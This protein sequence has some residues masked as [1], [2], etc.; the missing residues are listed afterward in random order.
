[1][2]TRSRFL[3]VATGAAALMAVAAPLSV[4]AAYP[5]KPITM[6]VA[7][8]AGG[9][10]DVT[11]RMLAPYIEKH[12][13]G[14]RIEVV[15][16]PGAGGEIGFAAL[17]DSPADGYTI[18]FINTPNLVSIPIE[19]QARFSLDR[20]DP[21]INVVDD[22]GIWTVPADSPFKTLSEAVAHAKANPNAV[23]VGTTGVGSDDQL[24]MLLVQRQ[25]G[26]QFTHVPFSGS[27]ANQKAMLAKKIQVCAQNLG[28]GLRA[29]ATEQVRILG[30]MSSERWKVAPDLPTFK[31]Q[32]YAVNM[33]SL[34]GI[35]APK[36]LPADIR[37]KLVDAL[38]KAV[39]DPEFVAKAEAKETFQPLR[40]LASDAFAGEL[41]QLDKELRAL[42]QSSPWLK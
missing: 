37:A 22:P 27:A 9:S 40:V 10:T 24:A 28:E 15:N 39:G 17:A 16:R 13:G 11:A 3:A 30:V 26:V 41:A 2:N 1:M 8:D 12:L 7:Y 38:T 23:T 18:G 5:E 14:A 20:L 35:G 21:L 31:E 29:T 34:R 33:A 6:V 19:R 4:Q 25:A 42:W 32:G 36:G